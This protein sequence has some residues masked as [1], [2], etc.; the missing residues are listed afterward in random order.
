MLQ[1]LHFAVLMAAVA[2]MA[3][4]ASASVV[5]LGDPDPFGYGAEA[6]V[7]VRGADLIITLKNTSASNDLLGLAAF[8]FNVP[9]GVTLSNLTADDAL[10][11]SWINSGTYSLQAAG[12]ALM[13]GQ[14]QSAGFTYTITFDSGF[15]GSFGE[16]SL[17]NGSFYFGADRYYLPDAPPG[18]PIQ[19]PLPPAVGVGA[20]M[21]AGLAGLSAVR[22]RLGRTARVS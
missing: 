16:T 7:E 19:N 10:G 17:G 1:K 20:S 18:A 11:A 14:G 6:V 2:A 5:Y 8:E 12:D 21:L 13:I 3:G 4:S 9:T 22:K 15:V